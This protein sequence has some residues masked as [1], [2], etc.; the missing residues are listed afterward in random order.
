M[1]IFVRIAAILIYSYSKRVRLSTLA[2][3][4]LAL[5][6]SSLAMAQSSWQPTEMFF[7]DAD[8]MDADFSI[9]LLRLL[10][11]PVGST[12]NGNIIPP[13]NPL[14]SEMFN[15]Y[16]TGVLVMTG[17]L[18]SYSVVMSTI[19]ISQEGSQAFQGK[20]SPFLIFRIVMGSSLLIP[21]FG[22]FSGVQLIVMSVVV[23]GIGFANTAWQ[24]AA[25]IVNSAAEGG[26]IDIS[27]PVDEQAV[28]LNLMYKIVQKG[29]STFPALD[30]SAWAAGDYT[31]KN[32][33]CTEEAD[34]NLRAID[35]L[36]MALCQAFDEKTYNVAKD[37]ASASGTETTDFN[38]GVSYQSALATSAAS[39][40]C[41]STQGSYACFGKTP[42]S[43]SA[44]SGTT[45]NICGLIKFEDDT[46]R[47]TVNGAIARAINVANSYTSNQVSY[48]DNTSKTLT[49][50][51]KAMF[52]NCSTYNPENNTGVCRIQ[53]DLFSIAN[54]YANN[55]MSS[56]NDLW[57]TNNSSGSST[58][59]AVSSAAGWATA[60]Q[61]F[62]EITKNTS[63]ST[64]SDSGSG[65]SPNYDSLAAS[66]MG[67]VGKV[68]KTD[69]YVPQNGASGYI[70]SP[71]CYKALCFC[72]IND[73]LYNDYWGQ[74]MP[75]NSTEPQDT[76][77]Y[78]YATAYHIFDEY[79]S[80]IETLNATTANTTSVPTASNTNT[81]QSKAACYAS[82]KVFAAASDIANLPSYLTKSNVLNPLNILNAFNVKVDSKVGGSSSTYKLD[83]A[84]KNMTISM[85]M[86]LEALS[87]MKILSSR[88][89][90][91]GSYENLS[92][93]SNIVDDGCEALS[94]SCGSLNTSYFKKLVDKGCLMI[95]SC[96]SSATELDKAGLFGMAA[97]DQGF[98][99]QGQS[100]TV[101]ADP[102]RNLTNVGVTMMRASVLYY[103]VTMQQVFKS[104]I[105]ITLTATGIITAF[106]IG[107]AIANAA[108][109][110]SAEGLWTG[111]AAL[112]DS[113]FDMM[114]KLDKYALELFLPLGSAVAGLLFAQGVTLGVYLP[115]LAFFYY[116]FG[117]LG[118]AMAVV[119]A[120]IAAP[121]VALGL[122]HPEGHDLL[123]Q[124]EQAMM[125]LLGVFLRP[126]CMVIGL[127]FAISISQTAM[128]LI[129]N[130]FLF[131]MLDFF[132]TI[133]STNS[134]TGSIGQKVIMICTLGLFIVY[135]YVVFQILDMSYGLI[136]QIP[137]RILRWIGG[138][139][140]QTAQM[141]Q[142]A[143]SQI[144]GQ[145]GQMA[146]AG[147]AGAGQASSKGVDTG[148]PQSKLAV[149]G[150]SDDG[151]EEGND[152]AKNEGATG[153]GNPGAGETGSK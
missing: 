51:G 152:S 63:I 68:M 148:G 124:A 85:M 57:R 100:K 86:A 107:F 137:D 99:C 133:D 56:Y 103:I 31:K 72:N 6:G 7:M 74:I 60:G 27:Q 35:L 136:V 65:S 121:L 41:S 115:F 64:S 135:S 83:H 76:V 48:F 37:L 147:A 46:A 61:Y 131:V 128:S 78:S 62:S 1:F 153:G 29:I 122:T 43:G 50:L 15:I 118:W 81:P 127:F 120:M 91:Q 126:I 134:A 98:I 139:Q 117:V 113:I 146:Q 39:M 42:A 66:L 80:R 73:E 129:N 16:N 4:A 143:V 44:G 92:E 5:F 112:I 69:A 87:G 11:G 141:V 52:A 18:I 90:D 2:L 138:P 36:S 95:S 142:G 123:G 132:T 106:K 9:K 10:F 149:G 97:I 21:S 70:S 12:L 26:S 79:K 130:G 116:S 108:T 30:S 25:S 144:K 8:V 24:E 55:L 58:D 109:A 110:G 33:H 125:L 96:P 59:G 102:I 119:E 45:Q 22:G 140:D 14:I 38:F 84:T 67:K 34:K 13:S 82:N 32:E 145:T 104:I 111:A 49:D 54:T 23:N 77:Y 3:Y 93:A 75:A 40:P 47:D 94:S 151:K 89:T 105:G 88:V 101:Y 53:N 17:L 150:A 19:T 28:R 20:V 114:F 71:Y